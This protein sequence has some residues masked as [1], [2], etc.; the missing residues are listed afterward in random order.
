MYIV[1]GILPI[2]TRK[3]IYIYLGINN[4]MHLNDDNDYTRTHNYINL[5]R[6]IY[7]IV[8]NVKQKYYIYS[9]K[10]ITATFC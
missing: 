4:D 6:V 3:Y 1:Y 7:K 9:H 2:S 5:C 8:Q 10:Y